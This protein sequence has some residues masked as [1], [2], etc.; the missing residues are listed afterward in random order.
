MG[1]GSKLEHFGWLNLDFTIGHEKGLTHRNK[2]IILFVKLSLFIF[3]YF[4]VY[5]MYF[6]P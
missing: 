2:I 1:V 6:S 3:V 4:V 5:F